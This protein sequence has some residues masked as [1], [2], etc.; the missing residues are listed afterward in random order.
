MVPIHACDHP[1]D[2]AA[3]SWPSAAVAVPPVR[4][5]SSSVDDV[6]GVVVAVLPD[7][8]CDNARAPLVVNPTRSCY[9]GFALPFGSCA[10]PYPPSG[11][12]AAER[13]R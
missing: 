9:V 6:V 11:S 2:V 3:G 1:S 7:G 5:H 10:D 4:T 13:I 8:C 12:F